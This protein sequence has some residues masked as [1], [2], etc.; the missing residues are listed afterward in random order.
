VV[1]GAVFGAIIMFFVAQKNPEWV[2][3]T[4]QKQRKLSMDGTEEVDRLKKQVAE[5][6]LEKKIEAKIAELQAKIKG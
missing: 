6:E 1:I 3:S 5:M 2:Q 4:Y